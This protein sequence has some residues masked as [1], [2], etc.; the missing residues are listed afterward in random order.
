MAA[1]QL[2]VDLSLLTPLVEKYNGRSRSDLL[3]FLHEAQALYGWLPREVLETIGKTLRVPLA[4]IHGVVEFY[5]MFYTAPTARR[6]VRVCADLACSH[7]G[8]Q[9]VMDAVSAKLGLHHGE[10]SAGGSVTY[11]CVTCLGMCEHAP[12]ALNGDQPAGSLTPALVDAFVDGTLPEPQARPYGAPRLMLARVGKVD[13]ASLDDYKQQG[14]YAVLRRTLDMSPE[15]VIKTVESLGIVGRGGA[16]FPLGRKWHFTRG[17]P[18][19]P[20][21]KHIVVNADESEPGTFKD[22]CLMEEDP[23]AVVEAM[24][25]AAYAVGAANGWIFVRGEYPRSHARLQHAVHLARAAGCLGENILGKDGFHFD[26]TV[27]KGAG[28]NIENPNFYQ[29]EGG[30]Y[31]W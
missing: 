30:S 17:A 21:E 12:A 22:R 18:G 9:Q 28:A 31:N 20:A 4:D 3:P 26:I 16:M 5:T 24:T 7:A 14:G 2:S 6:V 29:R 10:T 8:G 11:E 19:T 23:F 13:P 25:V 15:A 1:L 27:R